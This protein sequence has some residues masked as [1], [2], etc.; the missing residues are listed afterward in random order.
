MFIKDYEIVDEITDTENYEYE[1]L[2][3]RE[4]LEGKLSL[5]EQEQSDIIRQL[6]SVNLHYMLS[7]ESY[8]NAFNIVDD[9]KNDPRLKNMN[10]IVFLQYK[11]KNINSPHHSVLDV[12][13]Y[14]KLINY[15]DEKEI[16]YGFDSCSANL[17][18]ESI[19]NREDRGRLEKYCEPCESKLMSYYINC[20]GVGYPCSFV[21]GIEKG[22]DVL[23]CSDFV[24]DVWFSG[25]TIKW[26]K[27]LIENN[28]NCPV[29][30]LEVV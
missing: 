26:R 4:F 17:Y 23:N 24:K 12:E 1:E 20:H 5:K 2:T 30:D 3:V 11:H 9:M 10:A 28:R 22:E 27:R 14:T 16:N 15:C 21:E 25:E 6:F 7:L 19:K 8:D 18:K 29:Y 13:K